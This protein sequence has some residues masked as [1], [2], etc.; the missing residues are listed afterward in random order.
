GLSPDAE[1]GP[2]GKFIA[3][4]DSLI[5]KG[6]VGLRGRISR[7]FLLDVL[8]GY[9]I[10]RFDAQSVLDDAPADAG[11]EADPVAAGFGQNVSATDGILV[12]VRPVVD[13]GFTT[14]RKL[15]QRVT[16]LY[17]KDF[18]TSFFTNYVHS[19][20]VFGGLESR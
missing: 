9:G 19:H 8:V 12:T 20:Y 1:T 2:Y 17:Q 5:A 13:L 15:G 14:Q 10:G 3:L 6:L 16:V 18:Q 11:A 4:P 7:V